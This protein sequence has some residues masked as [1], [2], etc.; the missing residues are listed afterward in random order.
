MINQSALLILINETGQYSQP[1]VFFAGPDHGGRRFLISII[2]DTATV[3]EITGKD[4][5]LSIF[6]FSDTPDGSITCKSKFFQQL[7]DFCVSC[8]SVFVRCIIIFFC[9]I[10]VRKIRR[11]II[12]TEL[13]DFL[14]KFF[15]GVAVPFTVDPI[16]KDSFFFRGRRNNSFNNPAVIGVFIPY[17]E[18]TDTFVLRIFC[19][20]SAGIIMFSAVC[21]VQIKI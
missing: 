11:L 4:Q 19:F 14:R 18:Q 12:F 13:Q 9:Y 21:P 1:P 15:S 8:F 2:G 6:H 16:Q 20:I 10:I 17:G 5:K 3:K 7:I